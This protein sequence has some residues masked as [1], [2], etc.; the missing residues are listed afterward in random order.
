M[1]KATL[2]TLTGPAPDHCERPDCPK[3]PL[4]IGLAGDVKVGLCE[5][6]ETEIVEGARAEGM[7]IVRVILFIAPEDSPVLF[8]TPKPVDLL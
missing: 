7:Q 8:F 1:P 6:H 3:S 5:E 2:F 4:T